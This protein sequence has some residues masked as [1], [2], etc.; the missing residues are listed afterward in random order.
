LSSAKTANA[1]AGKEICSLVIE[2][3]VKAA[4]TVLE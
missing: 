1:K 2:G 4:N 3:F